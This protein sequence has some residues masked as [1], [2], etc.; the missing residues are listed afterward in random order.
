M[1]QPDRLLEHARLV[2]MLV[3]MSRD[4]E[5]LERHIAVVRAELDAHAEAEV[6]NVGQALLDVERALDLEDA[7][8]QA[9]AD[10]ALVIAVCAS[11]TYRPWPS[12]PAVFRAATPRE[13]TRS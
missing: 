7:F 10:R 8:D 12:P 11:W 4:V 3:A 6:M 1:T 13:R 5:A 9:R 2:E